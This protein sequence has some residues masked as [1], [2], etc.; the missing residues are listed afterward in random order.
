MGVQSLHAC[1][2]LPCSGEGVKV[3]LWIEKVEATPGKL[4]GEGDG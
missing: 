2:N 3:S 1:A 4:P